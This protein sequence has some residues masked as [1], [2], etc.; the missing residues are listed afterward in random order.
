MPKTS[1]KIA[2]ILAADVVNYSRLMG[3]DDEQTL[4][5]LKERREIFDRLVSEFEGQEF[6]SVGD[7]L[8][9]QFASAVN[10][11]RCAQAIQRA[12]ARTNESV[13][14]ERRMS[15]RIGINL[16]DVIEENGALFGDGVNVAARLQALAEPGGILV[17]GSVYEQ[18]R[19][20]LDA[21]SRSQVPARSRTSP[22]RS[23][24]TSSR[25]PWSGISAARRRGPPA[26]WSHRC[27]GVSRRRDLAGLALG[28]DG[29][30]RRVRQPG[31]CL[32]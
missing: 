4:A 1:R 2:A 30:L 11:V 25:S 7:S 32:P 26:P 6:G 13:A 8:M 3:V 15:L 24:L 22:S 27:G 17:S 23:G 20:R 16:G 28:P 10:A 14:A 5:L 18:V 29:R 9:A 12:I 19:N 31:C 21:R